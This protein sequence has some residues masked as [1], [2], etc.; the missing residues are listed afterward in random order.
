MLLQNIFLKNSNCAQ[1][2][3]VPAYNITY[4][5]LL[6]E[7]LCTNCLE[8]L[9]AKIQ[10]KVVLEYSIKLFYQLYVHHFSKKIYFI[11]TQA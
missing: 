3:K 5:T 11:Q 6:N 9:S 8:W 2:Y 4:V 7:N 10:I 1:N